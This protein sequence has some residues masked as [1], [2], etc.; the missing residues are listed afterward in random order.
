MTETFPP[1]HLE[2]HVINDDIEFNEHQQPCGDACDGAHQF[3]SEEDF[4]KYSLDV[5]PDDMDHNKL[6]K[7][8]KAIPE[9]F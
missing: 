3:H 4:P 7:R 9:E 2:Q 8:Y 1:A 5:L 6:N